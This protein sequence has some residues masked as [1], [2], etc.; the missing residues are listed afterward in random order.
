MG[1]RIHQL[2]SL[3]ESACVFRPNWLS[4]LAGGFYIP[5]SRVSLKPFTGYPNND[6]SPYDDVHL[7]QSIYVWFWCFLFTMLKPFKNL[8]N[9]RVQ[10][11]PLEL[12]YNPAKGLFILVCRIFFSRSTPRI[13]TVLSLCAL[14]AVTKLASLPLN[15]I[16]LVNVLKI[17][18]KAK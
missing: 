15:Q 8:Q 4:C 16:L 18:A 10:L 12:N 6:I 3:D 11:L 17:I 7:V 13:W 14:K 1:H 9:W 2:D 5:F